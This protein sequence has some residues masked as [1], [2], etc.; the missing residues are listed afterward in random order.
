MTGGDVIYEIDS[1]SSRFVSIRTSSRSGV[2]SFALKNINQKHGKVVISLVNMLT[3]RVTK[4]YTL[5][6]SSVSIVSEGPQY[7]Y[8]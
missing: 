6:G 4:S 2:D 1:L 8:G 5:V 7:A 3:N